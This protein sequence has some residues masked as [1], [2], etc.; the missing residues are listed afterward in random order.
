MHK[1]R[2]IIRHK[3]KSGSFLLILFL[4]TGF[5]AFSQETV[6]DTTRIIHPKSEHSPHKATMYSA[7]LPG[8]G[9]V[10]NRKYW[11]VPLVVGGFATLG[12]FINFNNEVYQTY[13][14]AYSDIIDNNDF[15]NSY[16]YL[17]VNPSLLRRENQTDFTESLRR[18]KDN[19]RR[20]RD[21]CIIGTVVFY[22][23]NVIDAS[24][25]AHFFNF[26]I[27]DDLTVNWAP[28]PILC[29]ENKGIGIQC[30]FTF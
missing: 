2:N 6:K 13:K 9:Q 26:D 25:D 28:S 21:L 5:S 22:A 19:W 12:Y 30:R 10:Y 4:T 29:M 27:S 24:V 11:K 3:L 18:A 14:R 8:L 17:D 20:N 15:T 16:L 1:K 23:A 7:I